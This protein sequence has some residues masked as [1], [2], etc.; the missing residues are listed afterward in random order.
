MAAA[1]APSQQ[2]DEFGQMQRQAEADI[3][4]QDFNQWGGPYSTGFNTPV[5]GPTAEETQ[6]GMAAPMGQ[7][8]PAQGYQDILGSGA[9]LAQATQFAG[10]QTT[11]PGQSTSPYSS[12]YGTYATPQA[13]QYGAM[14]QLGLTGHQFAQGN[15]IGYAGPN[16]QFMSTSQNV[17]DQI[18]GA[19]VD[20]FTNMPL[21]DPGTMA[22]EQ[23]DSGIAGESG[24]TQGQG[25]VSQNIGMINAGT[26]QDSAGTVSP[27]GGGMINMG[28]ETAGTTVGGRKFDVGDP[29][30][31]ANSKASEIA[32]QTNTPETNTAEYK[33]VVQGRLDTKARLDAA[34]KADPN[35]N[36]GYPG[37]SNQELANAYNGFDTTLAAY[38]AINGQN[39]LVS[40]IANNSIVVN[41]ASKTLGGISGFLVNRGIFNKTSGEEIA[42]MIGQNLAAGLRPGDSSQWEAG[43]STEDVEGPKE[44]R[45]FIQ[46]YPWAAELDPR[47]IKYLIDNPAELQDLLGE[48]E[49]V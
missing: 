43:P 17:E 4:A 44:I 5:A 14:R 38:A 8:A 13:S 41:M 18:G 25:G 33:Q 36:S 30:G 12:D 29:I 16:S 3:A 10:P 35:G 20:S 48:K 27:S 7:A 46:Q 2:V 45:A 1:A 21:G 26:T 22:T 11:A 34:A 15:P 9:G 28:S 49:G 42:E 31:Y 6:M 19:A 40:M 32:Q 37:V 24:A 39:S 47:Y 23:F